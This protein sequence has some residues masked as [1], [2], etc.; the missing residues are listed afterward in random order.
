MDYPDHPD[1]DPEFGHW[2]AGF[3]DGEGCFQILK[4]T[5]G[6]H[7][8]Y[9]CRFVMALRADDGA[10]LEEIRART[11]LGTI[12]RRVAKARPAD[13]PQWRFE[14]NTKESCL[15]L[16]RLL[17]RHPLRAKKARDYALWREAVL[18]WQMVAPRGPGRRGDWSRFR[19]LKEML[20]EDKKFDAERRLYPAR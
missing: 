14:V 4:R 5:G 20:N 3:V 1:V 11:G 10:I 16:V 19:D 2:L 7:R 9:R 15:A 6:A 18:E 12:Y 13:A 8:G 17:D